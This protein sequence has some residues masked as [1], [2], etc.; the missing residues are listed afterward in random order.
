MQNKLPFNKIAFGVLVAIAMLSGCKSKEPKGNGLNGKISVSGAF[1]LYPMVIKWSEEFAKL[2]PGVKFD[3]QAGGAGK[4]MTDALTQ[5]VDLGMVSR[6]ITPEE[7]NKG[8]FGIAVAKDAVIPTISASNPYLAILNKKGV[9]KEKLRD[10]WITGKIKNWKDLTG[11]GDLPLR[12][13]TR[14]DAAGAPET[15]AKYLGGG[16]EDLLGTGVF[17]DPGLAEAIMNEKTAI[18]YNNVN[19]VYNI[20]D[21]KP[22]PG[23]SALPIDLNGNG[24]LD[25][26]ENFYASLQD[27]NKAIASN[28]YPSPPARPLYLVVK[29]KPQNEIVKA[30]LQWILTDGQK[31]VQE[32]GYVKLPESML[33]GETDKLKK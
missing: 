11:N 20:S 30:F 29:D 33:Q 15:W 13:Y 16:Q 7:V 21:G 14:S 9:T 27:I 32:T 23:I 22:H 4:G 18:G 17:G 1:A 3:V 2:H 12:V 10:I 24:S 5:N 19:Y 26:D 28:K 6:D 25:A 31:F 8:A